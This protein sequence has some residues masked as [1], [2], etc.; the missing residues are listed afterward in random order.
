MLRERDAFDKSTALAVLFES[1][2]L[3]CITLFNIEAPSIFRLG[4]SML[5]ASVPICKPSTLS[6]ADF[7]EL[8]LGPVATCVFHISTFRPSLRR[9]KSGDKSPIKRGSSNREKL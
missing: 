7:G 2:L 1:T 6:R 5:T 9:Y 8:V 4:S 3:K